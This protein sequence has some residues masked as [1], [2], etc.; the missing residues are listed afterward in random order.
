MNSIKNA[1]LERRITDLTAIEAKL[2][3]D[4]EKLKK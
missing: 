2:A 4:L 3:S 1:N